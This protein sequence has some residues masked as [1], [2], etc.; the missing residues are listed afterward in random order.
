MIDGYKF[1][2]SRDGIGGRVFWRCSRRECKATAVTVADKVEHIRTVHS[3]QPPVAAEFFSDNAVRSEQLVR[4]NNSASYSRSRV[5]RLNQP[6]PLEP[7]EQNSVPAID[8]FHVL[9]ANVDDDL[10]KGCLHN[11]HPVNNQPAVCDRIS[12]GQV[13][14]CASTTSITGFTAQTLTALITHLVETNPSSKPF[15]SST[16]SNAEVSSNLVLF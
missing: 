15:H 6:E 14:S 5:R 12:S 1:T 4:F 9:P 8:N 11:G 16:S 13:P 10:P 2:K 3:H 7:A